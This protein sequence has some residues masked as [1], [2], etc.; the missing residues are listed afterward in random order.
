MPFLVTTLVEVYVVYITESEHVVV[1]SDCV[2]VN[3]DYYFVGNMTKVIQGK[4]YLGK[5]N[6][7]IQSGL[8]LT[9]T[10]F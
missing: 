7:I 8:I 6:G 2:S 4:I 9:L 1:M 5:P 3:I 10:I